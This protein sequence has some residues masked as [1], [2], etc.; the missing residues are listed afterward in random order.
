MEE[1]NEAELESRAE[2][3]IKS[4]SKW[5]FHILTPRCM[6]NGRPQNAFILENTSETKTYIHYSI[7]PLKELGEKLVK[8]LHGG[9]VSELT[10]QMEKT[11]LSEGEE[12][13]VAHAKKLNQENKDWHH[14]MLFPDCAFNESDG[15]WMFI[16]EG[17][18]TGDIQEVSYSKEPKQLLLQIEPLF[19][20]KNRDE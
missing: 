17:E 6:F 19:Y 15:K 10:G 9:K 12:E 16:F 13:I 7:S 1:V 5:H 18:D 3:I 2:S 14:H 11:A 4:G 8:K 20:A